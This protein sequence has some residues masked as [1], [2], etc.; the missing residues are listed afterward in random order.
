MGFNCSPIHQLSSGLTTV[1]IRP[2]ITSDSL[3]DIDSYIVVQDS[4][5]K[6]A[7]TNDCNL[8]SSDIEFLLSKRLN[9]LCHKYAFPGPWPA[10]FDISDNN[11]I[12]IQSSMIQGSKDQFLE[13]HQLV[14]PDIS[15]PFAGTC[16]WTASNKHYSKYR[17]IYDSLELKT[18]LNN[19]V[20]IPH[21]TGISS[22]ELSIDGINLLNER[23]DYLNPDSTEPTKFLHETI[24]SETFDL[25]S[26]P[27]NLYINQA[28]VNANKR[29][30][31][32]R[33]SI[34]FI[35]TSD[36]SICIDLVKYISNL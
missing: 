11:K 14:M 20:F 35:Y 15:V 9:I 19:N 21:E 32:T 6:F 17:P 4:T 16:Q 1:E 23:S 28:F 36:K 7:N 26:L 31:G 12:E 30:D 13:R 34:V 3:S 5:A 25:T 24:F 29:F 10:L 8:A 22:I 2:C 18:F 33:K 27:L